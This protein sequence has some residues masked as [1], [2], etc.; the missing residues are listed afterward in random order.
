MK[1]E[2]SSRLEAALTALEQGLE[3]VRTVLA[4]AAAE[5]A[6]DEEL[7]GRAEEGLRRLNEVLEQ[8]SGNG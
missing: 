4:T 2:L 7:V 6:K 8:H 1:L 3:V 5:A